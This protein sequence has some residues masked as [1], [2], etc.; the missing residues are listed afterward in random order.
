MKNKIL[1]FLSKWDERY[2]LLFISLFLFSFYNS[3][4]AVDYKGE[5]DVVND[6]RKEITGY[7]Y[8]ENGEPVI[9]VNVVEKGV[10]TVNGTITDSDGRFS[11]TVDENAVIQLSY[12]GYLPQDIPTAGRIHFDIVLKEDTKALDEIVVIGYGSQSRGALTTSISKLD[13]KVLENIPFANIGSALQGTVSGVRVQSTSGQPG[14]APRIIIRGGTSINN[15][16]GAAPLYIID[17]IQR[18]DMNDI[19]T[20]DIESIQVL[21]DAAATSIYGARGSNGVIIVT[22]KSG[23]KGRTTINYNADVSI[24][25]TGRKYN[26]ASARDFL[27]FQRVGFYESSKKTPSVG[28]MLNQATA[29]GIGNDLTNLTAFTPQYLSPENEYKLKEGWETMQDPLDPSKTIIFKGTDFQDLLFRTAVS[30]NHNLSVSGGTDRSTFNIGLGYLGD[31]GVAI[32]TNFKRYSFNLSGTIRANEKLQFGGKVLYTHSSNNSVADIGA[33]FKNNIATAPT[34]K[35]T[36]EDGTL[37]P[38]RLFIQGNPIYY[39]NTFKRKN[40]YDNLSLAVDAQWDI[41]EGLTFAPQL[42][43]FKRQYYA[44]SF[45]KAYLDG[46][47]TPVND[48]N[49]SAESTQNLLTQFN[50]VLSYLRSIDKHNIDVRIGYEYYRRDYQTISAGGRGAATDIIPTLNASAE[51]RSVS[52][53][54]WRQ[55]MIGYFG[56]LNY[57]FDQK[58]LFSFTARYDGASNLGANN[59]W[60]F[61]PGISAGWNLHNEEF[62]NSLSGALNQFKIRGSY[63]VNG[64]ISG[65]SA[66]QAQ[67]EYGVGNRYNNQAAILNTILANQD[68]KWEE[69]KTFDIG[70]DIGLLNSRINFVFDWFNR[71]TNNLLTD[72]TLPHSAGFGTIKTNLGSLRNRGIELELNA[73]LLN[74]TSPFQWNIAFNASKI[75]NRILKLPDNGIE[76]NRIGGV[77]VWDSSRSDYAYLGGIQEGGTM[78]ELYAYKQLSIYATDEEAA[79][80]PTDTLVPGND[81]TKHGGDV[82]WLDADGNG[83]IDSRDRVYV[84]NTYPNWTG[85]LANYFSYKNWGL[86]VRLDYTLGHTIYYETGARLLGNFSGQAGLSA[87][88]NKSWQKQGDITDIPKY[89]WA[90]QNQKSNLYRG[91]SRYYQSGDFLSIR[92]VTLSYNVP[93]KILGK[94][95]I[96]GLRLNV[97][98]NNLHYFTKYEGLNPEE[99]GT[100]NGRYPLPKSI[101][102]GMNLSF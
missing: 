6:S 93:T 99:G 97:T 51:P 36:F 45:Q 96:S 24:S 32:Q 82:N 62:W 15:P 100:D 40:T 20:A 71:V 81:K 3:V 11:L 7:I 88:I 1:F 25:Q 31:E 58:Y 14:A 23:K 48:R 80:G 52:G 8:D 37:A 87:D 30:Q 69:A 26:L 56:R 10:Q 55:V 68:L 13:N 72:M 95:K 35:H 47:T 64:N 46:P 44:R 102:L 67:G 90:D 76:N 9:G 75:K 18:L 5:N 65:L 84:G 54:E 27:Y 79:K 22:T 12:I 16:N 53:S 57:N 2:I 73:Q 17:G 49:A 83:I 39:I 43:V 92:E 59:K 66:Y 78:G 21:K 41:L 91:N 50:G 19:N 89:Y 34:T 77:Y 94:M 86:V 63:G 74:T 4:Y 98:G 101:I 29:G 38:G 42:S 85:G 70:I 61:F 60:G 33:V 28:E